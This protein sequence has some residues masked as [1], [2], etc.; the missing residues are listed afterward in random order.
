M[1]FKFATPLLLSSALAMGALSFVACGGDDT[2][3]SAVPGVSS[4]SAPEQLPEVTPTTSIDTAGLGILYKSISK[5]QFKGSISIVLDDPESTDDP[6]IA[7]FA[8]VQFDVRSASGASAG[9]VIV[10]SPVDYVN[11][12]VTE[13]NLGEMGVETNLDEGYTECGAFFLFIT[14]SRPDGTGL[15]AAIPFERPTSKCVVEVSSSSEAHIAAPLD[16]VRVKLNTK[17]ANCVVLSSNPPTTTTDATAGDICLNRAGTVIGL[18]SGTVYK[19]AQYANGSDSDWGNDWGKEWL[20]TDP[21]TTDAFLYNES[22]LSATYPDF[23]GIEDVF[24]VAIN[25]SIY[26]AN[27]GSAM[28]FVAFI[29]FEGTK[30]PNGDRDI[31]LLIYKA[32]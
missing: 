17:T 23:L 28:G 10:K 14:A 22:S 30:D 1:N 12:I 3:I 9:S 5:V 16:S 8:N 21:V 27:S 24:F 19:F 20:P 13:V 26:V 11:N 7:R 32:K 29:P 18:S 31:E 15:Q 2:G 6:T 4:S 25:P